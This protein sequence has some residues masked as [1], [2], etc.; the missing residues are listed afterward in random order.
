[1]RRAPFRIAAHG[2]RGA[3]GV[4]P[5]N[6]LEAF[7]YAIDAGA[8]AVE[9][10]LAV[11]RDDVLVVSH[12]PIAEGQVIRE[13]LRASLPAWIPTLEDVCHLAAPAHIAL[14]IELKS[15]PGA[16]QYT[17]APEEFAAMVLRVIDRHRFAF[18]CMLQSFD[19]RVVRAAGD[20]APAVRRGAL[21][22]TGGSDFVAVAE[23]AGGVHYVAPQ[24]GLVTPEKVK[25]A[26]AAGLEVIVWTVNAPGDWAG[27]AAAGVDGIIADDPAALV[28][29]LRRL[30]RA[31]AP[32][33][34]TC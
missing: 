22:E 21:F 27:M 26:H 17:P 20:L 19:F 23:A 34:E 3:R 1:M 7:A 10:D 14:N 5:E 15:D 24:Y 6:T 28:A 9:L 4:R 2:H 16:P 25:A 8:D 30:R 33:F 11:T 32:E 31:T 29:W 12:D 13:T 18:R